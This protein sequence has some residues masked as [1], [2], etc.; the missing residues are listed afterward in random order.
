MDLRCLILFSGFV[1]TKT[2]CNVHLSDLVSLVVTSEKVNNTAVDLDLNLRT[3]SFFS[4]D[5][6]NL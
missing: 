5:T 2:T 6:D 1:V 3:L 4:R